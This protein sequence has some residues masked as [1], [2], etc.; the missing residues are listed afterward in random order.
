MRPPPTPDQ[1]RRKIIQS[2]R[3][4]REYGMSIEELKKKVEMK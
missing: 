4:G 3:I 2:M 1:A